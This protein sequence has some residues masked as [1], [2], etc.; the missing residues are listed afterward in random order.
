MPRGFPGET[1]TDGRLR[2]VDLKKSKADLTKKG[3]PQNVTEVIDNYANGLAGTMQS[4]RASIERLSPIIV[5]FSTSH[6]FN[7]DNNWTVKRNMS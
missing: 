5:T 3:G 7:H 1:A 6:N 4:S 2:P